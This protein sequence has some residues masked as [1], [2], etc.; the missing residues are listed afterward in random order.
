VRTEHFRFQ[1]GELLSELDRLT[2]KV[3]VLQARI[4]ERTQRYTE[5]IDRLM[6]IPGIG[7]LTAWTLIAE[8]GTDMSRFP[9]PAHLASWCGLCP[10]NEESAGKRHSGRIGKGNRYL[11]TALIEAAWAAAR[12]N[13]KRTFFTTLFFRISR[14]AGRK[15]AAVAVAHRLLTVAYCMIR[16]GSRYRESGPDYFDRLHSERTKNRMVERLERLGFEV[17]LASKTMSQTT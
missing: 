9:S 12:I 2:A 3:A 13:R 5:L 1:L 7:R 10:G 4:S 6:E 17:H 15:K 14:R 16:D 11:R 8:I